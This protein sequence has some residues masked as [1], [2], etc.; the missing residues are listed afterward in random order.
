MSV[1]ATAMQLIDYLESTQTTTRLGIQGVDYLEQMKKAI[2]R[3]IPSDNNDGHEY[4]STSCWH[5]DHNYCS[6]K[7]VLEQP[8]DGDEYIR[9]KKPA[10]CKF[11]NARCICPCHGEGTMEQFADMLEKMMATGYSVDGPI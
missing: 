2:L 8:V 3:A 11:C 10:E 6:H 9:T 1:I 5:G 7:K 4:L